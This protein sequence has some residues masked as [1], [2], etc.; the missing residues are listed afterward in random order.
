MIDDHGTPY[1]RLYPQLLPGDDRLLYSRVDGNARGGLEASNVMV[2]DLATGKETEI[3][4]RHGYARYLPSGHLLASSGE[5]SFS[6]M[7]F[8]SSTL[9]ITGARVPLQDLI[10]TGDL[11][12]FAHLEVAQDGTIVFERASKNSRGKQL[13]WLDLNGEATEIPV[14][15]RDFREVSL[16]PDGT[17]AA[18]SIGP[19]PTSLWTFDFGREVLSAVTSHSGSANSPIWTPDGKSL[20]FASGADEES[21]GV[22]LLTLGTGEP[23]R[24]LAETGTVWTVPWDISPD[25]KTVAAFI[26]DPV[27]EN[28]WDI[29]LLSTDG[30][31]TP[32]PFS[33]EDTSE[34]QPVFSPDGNWIAFVSDR[35]GTDEI[36]LKRF[37]EQGPL[38]QVSNLGAQ[39]PIW[40]PDGSRLYFVSVATAEFLAVDMTWNG[41]PSI[42]RPQSLFSIPPR[43]R[44]TTSGPWASQMRDADR[45]LIIDQNLQAITALDVILNWSNE[46]ERL[47]PTGSR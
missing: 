24:R 47:A 19:E 26:W 12:T 17:R 4:D 29:V 33:S 21:W 38:I 31:T 18:L 34:M 25:G 7:P 5:N 42:G 15:A 8:D 16:S 37:P 20:V 45:L 9:R 22:S 6:L 41:T 11:E 3:L 2:L 28:D 14:A 40:A 35:T 23:A 36:Y 10:A 43:L 1:E 39:H 44:P 27:S 13:A 30:S 46:L 32:L